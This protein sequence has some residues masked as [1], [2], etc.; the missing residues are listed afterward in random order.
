[1]FPVLHGTIVCRL[2]E[3]VRESCEVD[4]TNDDVFMNTRYVHLW[5]GVCVCHLSV[6][7]WYVF[8]EECHKFILADLKILSKWWS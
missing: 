2:V 7:Q 8:G 5:S 1:M 3:E 6:Y 4:I